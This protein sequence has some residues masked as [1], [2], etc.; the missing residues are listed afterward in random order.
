MAATASS[1][2]EKNATNKET[3]VKDLPRPPSDVDSMIGSR[4]NH[5]FAEKVIDAFVSGTQQALISVRLE[6]HV[7][8]WYFV[9]MLRTLVYFPRRIYISSLLCH[10]AC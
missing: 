8:V 7:V 5:F 2:A 1:S 9:V 3:P 6:R 4:P 10:I